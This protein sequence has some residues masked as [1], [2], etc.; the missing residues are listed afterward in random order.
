VLRRN[1]RDLGDDV[2]DLRHIDT[3]DPAGFRL[4]ALIG[5]RFIDHVNGLVRHVAIVDIARGQLGGGAQ[6]FI[7][8]LDVVVALEPAFQATQDAD[9]VLHR[10]LADIDL[11]EAPRQGTVLLE[12]AA[13][14]L[15][16]GRTDA[17]NLTRRQQRLEQVG[18]I[19]HPA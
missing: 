13:E 15:E 5:A 8:V 1:P 12:D 17:T 6:G 2:L 3:L 10:R 19:H 16:G 14:L 4:Q 7:A 18:G 9:G 11:L